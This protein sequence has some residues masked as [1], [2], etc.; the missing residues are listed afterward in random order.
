MANSLHNR[1]ERPNKQFRN[2]QRNFPRKNDRREW[3][4]IFRVILVFKLK[5]ESLE[6]LRSGIE[7]RNSRMVDSVMHGTVFVPE[8]NVDIF[9]RKFEAYAKENTKKRQTQEQSSC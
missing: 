4:W 8:G 9:V 5:L 2:R 1:C 7:L 3:S 6:T